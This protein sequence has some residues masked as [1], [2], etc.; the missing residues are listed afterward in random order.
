MRIPTAV[1]IVIGLAVTL[2]VGVPSSASAQVPTQRQPSATVPAREGVI[3]TATPAAATPAGAP[4]AQPPGQPTVAPAAAPA[5]PAPV[6]AA[7]PPSGVTQ[8]PPAAAPPATASSSQAATAA[9]RS[10]AA[11]NFGLTLDGV[12]VGMM[13]SVE[14]G[15]A[16]AIVVSEKAGPDQVAK[17]HLSGVKYENIS[18]ATGLDSKPLNDWIAATMKGSSQRKNGSILEADFDRKVRAEREFFNALIAG[19]TFPTLDASSKDAAFMTI[20]I[21]PEYTRV[22]GGSGATISGAMDAKSQKRWTPASFRFEM[23]G[24]DG[25]KV[26][27]IESFTVGQQ[28]AESPVGEA[29]DYEKAPARLEF[30]NL[31]ITMAATGAQ[32]WDA[33]HDDFVIKGNAGDDREKN[34][35]VVYLDQSTREELG[36]VNLFNCGIFRLAPVNAE[37]GRETTARM[38]AELY[39]ERMDFVP[40]NSK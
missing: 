24:L 34:G 27:R 39:C 1:C 19:V 37:A 18:I 21:A 2:D 33:W 4:V 40:K 26:N 8:V 32:T 9:G 7:P 17:K 16:T 28:A 12:Q 36:R 29:R 11:A 15:S 14:G 38:A 6:S 22:K 20:Q 30:P 23:D 31:K 3:Q 35:A 10:Y 5:E 25:G 13:K